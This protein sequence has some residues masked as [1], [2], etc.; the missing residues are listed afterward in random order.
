[1]EFVRINPPDLAILDI[2]LKGMDELDTVRELKAQH[3]PPVIFLTT[4]CRELDEVLGLEL[5]A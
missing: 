3:N 5:G 4:R 2:C 1:M